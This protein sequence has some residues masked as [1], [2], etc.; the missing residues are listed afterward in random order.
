MG[1][2]LVQSEGRVVIVTGGARGLGW[3][4]AK[5]FAALGDQVV[6]ADISERRCTDAAERLSPSALGI[7]CDVS[8]EQS[9]ANL[10]SRVLETRGRID[11]LVN[12]AGIADTY[13]PSETQ[14]FANWTKRIDVN[15]NGAFLCSRL[16]ASSMIERRSG[17]IV[18]VGSIAGIVGL[19]MR[20]SYSASK[21]G[22]LMLTKVLAAEWG[23]FN[24][25][26]NAVAPGY[27]E[28]PPLMKLIEDGVVNGDKLVR[29]TPMGRLGQTH[30]IANAI[31]FL[32]SDKAS[33][34]NGVVLPV[35][36]GY[37]AWGSADEAY[38]FT[39]ESRKGS[40]ADVVVC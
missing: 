7:V 6:I 38:P 17:S 28:T 10:I 5:E 34:V 40:E 39:A 23:R 33:F 11:V 35:D 15:L 19:P 16:V 8:S 13:T 32:A 1:A 37:C 27:V 29:R 18:N 26:V 12:N 9:V 30:E 4:T 21:A 2:D 14:S 3:A 24:V 20:A 25:R 31:S 36:G 22:V